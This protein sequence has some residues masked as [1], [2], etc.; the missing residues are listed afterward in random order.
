MLYARLF[1]HSRI[2]LALFILLGFLDLTQVPADETAFDEPVLNFL[3]NG[4]FE[5]LDSSGAP[6]AWRAEGLVVAGLRIEPVK[7]TSGRIGS[8]AL[9]I[10]SEADPTHVWCFNGPFDVRAVASEEVEISCFYRTRGKPGGYL[11]FFTFGTDFTEKGFDTPYLTAE[12]QALEEVPK[13]QWR[14]LTW[15]VGCPASA[16]Q[17][18]LTVG[19][20]GGGELL[21]DDVS[22]RPVE[23]PI[24][25]EVQRRGELVAWPARREVQLALINRTSEDRNLRVNL[26][27]VR[28]DHVWKRSVSVRV[29]A[30]SRQPLVINYDMAPDNS[31]SLAISLDDAKQ[32]GVYD[33]W[34]A[35]VPALLT[36]SIIC[37]SFR[38]TI[39]SS[40]ST[41]EVIA[42]GRIIATDEL[43]SQ[44]ALE[45]ELGGA[46]RVANE[47]KGITR[48]N[49]PA[50]WRLVLPRQ[51]LLT[52]TYTLNIAAFRE[53]KLVATLPLTVSR[54]LEQ[55]NEV[56]YD[57]Q[58]RLWV[59]G[60]PTFVNG[61]YNVTTDDDLSKAAAQG[62]NLVVVPARSAGPGF[63][64]TA[65]E[66]GLMVIIH[67]GNPP[68]YIGGNVPSYWEHIVSK[69][70]NLTGVI[71]WHL[72]GKPDA[73]LI[74]P[75]VFR[76]H[77]AEIAKIDP[78]HPTVTLL[79]VISLLPIYAP[80]SDIVAV[81]PQP[82]PALPLTS[83]IDDLRA[84]RQA[85]VAGRPV[86]MSVQAVGR[87]WLMTGGGLDKEETGRPP[88]G[89]EHRVMSLLAV[90][91][92]AQGLLHH[93]YYFTPTGK[94]DDYLL[95]RDAPDLWEGMKHTNALL[96]QI[97]EPL[98][99]GTY[100]GVEVTGPV[101]VGAWE[102]N[103][104]LYVLA[105]NAEPLAALTTF[106][107]PGTA[108]GT[109][110]YLEGGNPVSCT[111][112]GRFV[113]D[114]PAYGARI[115]VTPLESATSAVSHRVG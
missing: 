75:S 59:N 105:V 101:H 92:G 28:K 10:S 29:S 62:F 93:G 3:Q 114:L 96:A 103:G 15:R 80:Y 17:A 95:P 39:L 74:R 41:E 34:M 36:G 12:Q 20:T 31:H 70:G 50:S 94:R 54:A 45:A 64:E 67:S 81:E 66:L 22:V 18:V 42:E 60:K 97:A 35:E 83:V 52:G 51:G 55:K 56:G 49:G 87:A 58:G 61:L 24:R 102:Y 16:T 44:L 40:I 71:G 104:R 85:S 8:K 90:V 2:G 77:Q 21:I 46:G 79:S 112:S 110:R 27:V 106:T 88:T 86:W 11:E 98:A 48:P 73:S 57:T 76:K 5:A 63:V 23:P 69:Y 65:H 108:P 4:T 30:D 113:D 37:P 26:E 111:G 6:I 78:Y 1:F 7:S 33:T 107:V 38:G 99:A 100:R 9:C 72:Q 25:M 43:C 53:G 115:Y 109:L 68:E 19:I 84:A 14:L 89:A 82:V 47:G 13:E 32:P 91:H